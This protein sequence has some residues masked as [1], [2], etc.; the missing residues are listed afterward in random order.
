M[1]EPPSDVAKDIFDTDVQCGVRATRRPPCPNVLKC[2]DHTEGQELE[3]SRSTATRE[4]DLQTREA[5]L[6]AG[7][8]GPTRKAHTG[9][10]E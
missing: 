6:K 5:A 7:E 10:A 3:I 8:A 2:S 4:A 9:T 1:S